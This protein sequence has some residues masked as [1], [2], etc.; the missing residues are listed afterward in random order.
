MV[1]A[2]GRL[3]Y[4]FWWSADCESAWKSL[5]ACMPVHCKGIAISG[6]REIRISEGSWS[7]QLTP[8]GG[9]DWVT[10]GGGSYRITRGG[11]VDR[12][13]HG[14]SR[15]GLLESSDPG[16]DPVRISS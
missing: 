4:F 8:G 11:G 2:T 13:T 5:S 7:Y 10:H 15:S 16:E 3:W 9:A 14:G 1:N 6:L 12:V